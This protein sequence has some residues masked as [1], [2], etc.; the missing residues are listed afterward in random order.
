MHDAGARG[1]VC[2]DARGRFAAQL[3]ADG[4]RRPEQ[5][6]QPPDADRHEIVAVPFVARREFLG[7]RM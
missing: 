1:D 4:P 6:R 2:S 7:D 5:P 3:L